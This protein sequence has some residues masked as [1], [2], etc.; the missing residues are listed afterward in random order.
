[1][2]RK[3]LSLVLL[4][5]ILSA[6]GCSSTR[7]TS[8]TKAEDVE[9]IDLKGKKVLAMVIDPRDELRVQA[10]TA[11]AAELSKRGMEGI[12]ANELIPTGDLGNKKKVKQAV[13][14]SGADGLVTLRLVGTEA[15]TQ[16]VPPVHDRYDSFSSY[17]HYG[18]GVVHAPGYFD[19]YGIYIVETRC[20]RVSNEKLL[21]SG[22]SETIDPDSV[23]TLVRSLVKEAG[24]VMKKQGLTAKKK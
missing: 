8:T 23:K 19:T 12:A 15:K 5:A 22:V 7:F 16:Y 18:W 9:P 21:W 10:E 14:A 4:V 24:K 13:Q 2:N 17:H 3:N 20:Y 11:L 6:A 1:M